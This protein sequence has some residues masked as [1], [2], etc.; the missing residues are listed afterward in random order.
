MVTHNLDKQYNDNSAVVKALHLLIKQFKVKLLFHSLIN[1]LPWIVVILM[2]GNYFKFS[3]VFLIVITFLFCFFT[4]FISTKFSRYQQVTLNTLLE[5][6]NR[7]YPQLEESAQL[8]NCDDSS[9]SILQVLQK[10]K[11]VALLER[12]LIDKQSLLLPKISYQ[13]SVLSLILASFI[14]LFI[15]FSS[16]WLPLISIS[17]KGLIEEVTVKAHKTENNKTLVVTQSKITITPPTYTMLEVSQQSELNAKA[18]VGST[19]HWQ[20]SFNQLIDNAFIEFS[21]GEKAYFTTQEHG[22]YIVDKQIDFTGIYRLGAIISGVEYTLPEVY[23]LTIE[24]DN[25]AKIKIITPKKTITEITT[26]GKT[27]VPTHVQITDD[28]K[29]DKVEILASIAKGS[30]ESVKFRDQTFSFDTKEVIDGVEN[31]YINWQ[32]KS[33]KMEPGDELYFTVKAWD[34]RL[35]TAQMT[36][37]ST[38][39]IRW[40]ED[41][42]QAVLSDGI[43]IDF[44]PEYF[45]SQRQ[46]I[47]ETIDLINDSSELSTDKFV[48]TSELLGVAQ[49]ELKEK[50]GQYLG[51]EVEDGGGSHAISHEA[52][53]QLSTLAEASEDA[54]D[55]HHHHESSGHA[56]DDFSMKGFGID[57][58]G[59]SELINQFGHNHEDADIGIM[60]RQDPKALMKRSITNM[61][62]A[63][64]HLMLSQPSKALP[65]EQE[66]LKYL[67]MA[68]KAERIYVK[69][70]GFEPPPVT[71]KRRYQGDLAD[72]LT[73]QRNQMIDLTESEKDQLSDLYRIL[74]SIT[75]TQLNAEIH[76]DNSITLG[77]NHTLLTA[78][79]RQII[80]KVKVQFEQ[81]LDSRPALIKYV[82]ILERVLLSNSFELDNCQSC[83]S[84]LTEKVWQ[85]LPEP[86]AKPHTLR[87]TYL[88]S[89]V[90]TNKYAEFLSVRP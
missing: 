88:N 7:H 18:I 30:G 25:K 83:L 24:K 76:S 58:S 15:Y 17:E 4:L 49:S 14:L 23:T 60:A 53:E 6:L 26:Q 89:D 19:L 9:L 59:G 42:Q 62:Q 20:L 55:D 12:L 46:I 13:K 10:Q 77:S 85:L 67:K 40:L 87:K 34:N 36:R 80:V 50:Y 57:K 28:F 41:E 35:P 39:I 69:R 16:V 45:K 84:D 44:M 21:H 73:Y 29:V 79:H 8:A 78:S 11:I 81:L 48:E 68:K 75:N 32:L 47:I 27:S 70:L 1:V 65:F 74:N 43:L 86:V 90:L 54:E 5:H 71:E 82:A 51:D 31:Y 38:K 66:A 72:V 56:S 37:S 33:L 52:S 64:L 3:V 2:M 22:S 61:W 63:E